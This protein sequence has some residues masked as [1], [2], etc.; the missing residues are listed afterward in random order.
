VS[1]LHA[2]EF[3]AAALDATAAFLGALDGRVLVELD[4][5]APM[6]VKNQR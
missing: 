1:V 4:Q 3:N 5:D 2:P 6:L